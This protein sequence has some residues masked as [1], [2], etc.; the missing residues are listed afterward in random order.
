VGNAMLEVMALQNTR[1]LRG[2]G[3]QQCCLT[4]R[5]V[6]ALQVRVAAALQAHGTIVRIMATMLLCSNGGCCRQKFCFFS[7]H[8]QDLPP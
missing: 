8:L 4:A 6:G 3:R 5:V 7:R 1:E 2:D